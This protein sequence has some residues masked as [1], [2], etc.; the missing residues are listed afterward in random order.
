MQKVKNW[1]TPYDTRRNEIWV[2]S[3]Q[4][5]YFVTESEIYMLKVNGKTHPTAAHEGPEGE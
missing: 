5:L 4:A 1:S 2:V 3:L